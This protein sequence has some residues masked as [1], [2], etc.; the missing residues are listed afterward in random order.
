MNTDAKT[1]KFRRWL[2]RGLCLALVALSMTAWAGSY[3]RWAEWVDSNGHDLKVLHPGVG[4][5]YMYGGGSA[6]QKREGLARRAD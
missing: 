6:S 2:F 5:T 4:A 3:W 1:H